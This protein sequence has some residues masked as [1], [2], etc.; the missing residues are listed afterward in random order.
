M[1]TALGIASVTH[2][3]KDL[4]NNGLI[5]HDVTGIINGNV[6]VSALPPDRMEVGTASEQSGLN[7]FMYQVQPNAGWRNEGLPGFNGRGQRVGNP[8]LALDLHYFLT[9]YGAEELHA[10]I[11]LGYGMQLLHETPVLSREAIRQSLA[12]PSTTSPT[13]LPPALRLLATAELA[14][15]VEQIKI[16]PESL[17][18]EDLSRFWTAFQ[19][20]YRASAAYKVTV[21]LIQSQKSTRSALPVQRRQVYVLPFRQPII[22]Q[23]KS[24]A[25]AAGSL[26]VDNQKI[27]AS[28]KLVV[29]GRQLKNDLVTA[30]IDGEP[31]VLDSVSDSQLVFT[32]P[33]TLVTGIHGVQVVHQI[34]MGLPLAE[35]RG[36]ASNLEAFVLSPTLS[37]VTY[38]NVSG[39]GT[40]P[41]TGNLTLTVNP[42]V[43]ARQQVVVLLNTLGADTAYSFRPPTAAPAA[44]PTSTL[45]VPVQ[46]VKP[47]TYLVRLQ[48][49]GAESPLDT[50][51]VGTFNSPQVTIA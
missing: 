29:V 21:V 49:D 16:T 28:Y 40:S 23:L 11:L 35:H 31:V 20:K 17:N 46:T 2:V 4:L 1:S 39:G 42:A 26:V 47:G 15:Q 7:L 38:A 36:G 32:L 9:A 13:G 34:L 45:T 22:D 51:A 6:Q 48:V 14:E 24:Q 18:A 10:E 30:T 3:L 5:D 27:L 43:L 37:A 8:P 44:L 25:P 50:D 33:N 12:A 19:A 41:R